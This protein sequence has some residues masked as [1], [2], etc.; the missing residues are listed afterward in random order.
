MN[1]KN[2]PETQNLNQYDQLIVQSNNTKQINYGNFLKNSNIC[3]IYNTNIF[4]NLCTDID[5]DDILIQKISSDNIELDTKLYELSQLILN[6]DPIN[7]LNT[8]S[9]LSGNIDEIYGS[10]SGQIS[11]IINDLDLLHDEINILSNTTD[12][13][14]NL[15]LQNENDLLISTNYYLSVNNINLSSEAYGKKLFDVSTE[16]SVISNDNES[17]EITS[18]YI[19]E[20]DISGKNYINEITHE[21]NIVNTKIDNLY[22]SQND[23]STNITH[24]IKC[25]NGEIE[26]E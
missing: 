10:I 19:V 12:I 5:N 13:K 1:V 4:S 22:F 18:Y 26:Y 17:K 2:L 15:Y 3:A 9:V 7:I 6:V 24:L 11:D 16:I 25:L 14:T 20:T 21:F 8:I 23:I